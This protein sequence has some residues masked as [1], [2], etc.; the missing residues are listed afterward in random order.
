MCG[1]QVLQD[2]A[3]ARGAE[4]RAGV[5]G[6]SYRVNGFEARENAGQWA[7][8][9]KLSDG[10]GYVNL[11]AQA[12]APLEEDQARGVAEFFQRQIDLGRKLL[13]PDVALDV[14]PEGDGLS[15]TPY[16]PGL[17]GA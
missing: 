6:Q 7:I 1:Q 3:A 14:E 9:G 4:V 8:V 13:G 17:T 16:V 12:V 2:Q 5:N 15:I 10:S 11:S